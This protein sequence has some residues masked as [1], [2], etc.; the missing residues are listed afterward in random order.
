MAANP[1]IQ[2]GTDG[3]WAIK[4]DNLLAYKKDDTR[5]FN[6]EFDFTRNTTATF[7]DKD[8][9]I[10]E[11]ATNTPRI[12]F[13]DDATGHLLLEPQRTNNLLRSEEFD[14]ASWTKFSGGTGIVPVVTANYTTSPDGSN[15]ADRV[16]FDKGSGTG[17]SDLSQMRQIVSDVGQGVSSVYI[18]SNT[19]D[20]YTMGIDPVGNATLITIT[21]EWQRFTYS[22]TT[23]DRLTIGLRASQTSNYADV[24]IWGAQMEAGSYATSYI[25]TYGSAT[26][27]NGE[28]CNNSG[29]V[30]DFNSEEGVLYA[31]IA[32]LAN[33]NIGRK[34]T[35][36]N[37]SNSQVVV[38]EYT[39]TSNQ[40]R[41]FVSNGSLQ[42]NEFIT[43]S[44]LTEFNKIAIKYK[45]NNFSLY[46][47]GIE[48]ATDTSG[49]TF[50]IGTLTNVNFDDGSGN[51]DFY[52][53]TKNLKVF[54]RAMSDGELYLLTVPQYQSYQE[55]ATALNY[56]L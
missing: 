33:D 18:K 2:L 19:S 46:V 43:I 10:K 31:E 48:V 26:T 53:K 24:S 41:V 54:K 45:E 37:G 17:G 40:I 4:E 32:A 3:N 52:G 25:P 39:S 12:D 51:A 11:S 28:V 27:R 23:N 14:N 36:N 42:F 15:N 34:I 8:G 16:V 56:T 21:P 1:S 55:M 44:D 30:Q 35:L 50:P 38:L 20:S 47:N 29:S 49:T 9:L 6:K 7:V 5:F 22:E 13:T